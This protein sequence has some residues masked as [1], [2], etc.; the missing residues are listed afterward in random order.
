MEVLFFYCIFAQ[1]LI[2]HIKNMTKINTDINKAPIEETII[3]RMFNGKEYIG[4]V[5]ELNSGKRFY[6][7]DT[8]DPIT[9][10]M[11]EGW[12]DIPYKENEYLLNNGCIFDTFTKVDCY[13]CK[14]CSGIMDGKI[15][16]YNVW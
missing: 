8:N 14:H 13:L 16:C 12:R 5:V 1:E 2:K 10:H 7:I 3:I 6:S 11:I 4:Q 9:R 15:K